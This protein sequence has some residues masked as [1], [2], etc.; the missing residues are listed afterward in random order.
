MKK[1]RL[2]K[3]TLQTLSPRVKTGVNGG[4]TAVGCYD[5]YDPTCYNTQV[6]TD[7]CVDCMPY[8]MEGYSCQCTGFICG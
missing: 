8:T 2:K 4:Y 3:E 1:L 5:T 7:T 6:P